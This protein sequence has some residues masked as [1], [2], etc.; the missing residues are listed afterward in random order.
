[1]DTMDHIETREITCPNGM[2]G[3]LAL[4]AGSGKAPVAITMHERYGHVKHQRDVAERFA[5]DGFI[6]LAPNMFFK[7]PDQQ[8]IHENRYHYDMT[9]PESVEYMA[10]ALDAIKTQVPRADM[11]KAAVM[12]VCQTGRHVFVTASELP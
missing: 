10:A 6:G 5:R 9:D 7:Y 3:Y 11:G 4:P 2:P 12:G 8:A 1:M